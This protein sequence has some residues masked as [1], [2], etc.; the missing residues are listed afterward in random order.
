MEYLPYK[1]IEDNPRIQIFPN[2]HGGLLLFSN[3]EDGKSFLLNKARE[4]V[5]YEEGGK[6]ADNCVYSAEDVLLNLSNVKDGFF[7]EE[8]EDGYFLNQKKY[9][10]LFYGTPYSERLQSFLLAPLARKVVKP[11]TPREIQERKACCPSIVSTQDKLLQEIKMLFSS[12]EQTL[13]PTGIREK[14]IKTNKVHSSEYASESDETLEYASSNEEDSEEQEEKGEEKD[15][16][17]TKDNN[18]EFYLKNIPIPPPPPEFPR[19]P[20]LPSVSLSRRNSYPELRT[21]DTFFSESKRAY[22]KSV[23]E[24]DIPQDISRET[25]KQL[26]KMIEQIRDEKTLTDIEDVINDVL[27]QE[28]YCEELDEITERM[29]TTDED[30]LMFSEDEDIDWYNE[31]DQKENINKERE[32]EEYLNNDDY[33]FDDE[34]DESYDTYS[35]NDDMEDDEPEITMYNKIN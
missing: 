34:D 3:V 1:R 29:I 27:S 31:E 10:G 4:V 6:N 15:T 25:L 28:N 35:E 24:D 17:E 30:L 7:I 21:T 13:K 18:K 14:L 11:L 32:E 9:A 2:E 33:S 23:D 12:G 16:K 20:T 26:D 8:V 22:E 19:L 5:V